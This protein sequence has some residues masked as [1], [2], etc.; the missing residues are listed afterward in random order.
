MK[1]HLCNKKQWKII[2][3]IITE[4]E[5]KTAEAAVW[6]SDTTF[7]LVISEE[8]SELAL[9]KALARL[10]DDEDWNVKNWKMILTII[11]LL[12]LLNWHT[13]KKY[14]YVRDIWTYF[15]EFYKQND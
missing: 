11:M 14:K 13:I 2:R 12:K 15:T 3:E 4:Q 1:S 10:T 8:I 6:I 9:N 5:R 7:L